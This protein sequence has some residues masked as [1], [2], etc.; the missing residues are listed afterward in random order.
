MKKENPEPE[1]GFSS[2]LASNIVQFSAP[3]L[4]AYLLSRACCYFFISGVLPRLDN[5]WIM[6]MARLQ[7]PDWYNSRLVTRLFTIPQNHIRS[8]DKWHSG[9]TD[10]VNM[11]ELLPDFAP[12]TA[13]QQT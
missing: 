6:A 1:A 10:G 3:L 5:D 4:I 12:Y 13:S 2:K 9:K 8:R 11:H 7:T